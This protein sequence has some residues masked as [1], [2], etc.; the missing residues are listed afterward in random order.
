[1]ATKPGSALPTAAIVLCALALAALVTMGVVAAAVLNMKP[2]CKTGPGS[3]NTLLG[4]AK[5]RLG[6]HKHGDGTAL[7]RRNTKH[8]NNTTII[9]FASSGLADATSPNI[10]PGRIA[11]QG[12][13][14]APVVVVSGRL[15][16]A[17]TSF[18]LSSTWA[19]VSAPPSETSSSSTFTTTTAVLALDIATLPSVCGPVSI[20]YTGTAA[21][22]GVVDVTRAPAF[23][24]GLGAQKTPQGAYASPVLALLARLH[25]SGQ[26]ADVAWVVAQD[27]TRITLAFG[28]P[29]QPC[30]QWC[31]SPMDIWDGCYVVALESSAT[32]PHTH[33]LLDVSRWMSYLPLGA[34]NQAGAAT[35][36]VL[37]TSTGCK[38]VVRGGTYVTK[39]AAAAPALPDVVS[40]LLQKHPSMCVI[41]MSA[42]LDSGATAVD[43]LRSR[44]GIAATVV[45]LLTSALRV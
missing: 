19:G 39:A 44:I 40:A 14:S 8:N 9:P 36:V 37:Q 34:A 1:M 7:R 31:W 33:A 20:T 5:A 17:E 30:F 12:A 2:M 24:L 18:Q 23:V 22:I 38:F 29:S 41:G 13:N 27:A 35:T 4:F 32:Q 25:A 10:V 28:I 6:P 45:P 3:R 15:G 21:A 26:L 11:A 43:V 16:A 42:G